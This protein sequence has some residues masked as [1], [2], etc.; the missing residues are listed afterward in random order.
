MGWE[1]GGGR[2]KQSSHCSCLVVSKERTEP[3]TVLI[4]LQ[5][6]SSK[7]QIIPEYPFNIGFVVDSN[8]FIWVVARY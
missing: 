4:Q 2:K 6:K 3:Q 1:L 5:Q 8:K 7:K